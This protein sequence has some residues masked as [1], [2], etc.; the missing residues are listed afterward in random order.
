MV[1]RLVLFVF[2]YLVLGAVPVAA[3]IYLV[4]RKSGSLLEERRKRR[5]AE[6]RA[7]HTCY[8]CSRL[9]DPDADCYEEGR[10][11]Y[12]HRCLYKLLNG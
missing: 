3:V 7:Q 2:L 10:G 5:L 1:A 9:C 12:H 8:V 11:W 6:Y 4:V